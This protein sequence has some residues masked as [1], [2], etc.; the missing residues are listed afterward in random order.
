MV[1]LE[2]EEQHQAGGLSEGTVHH[3]RP[4]FLED[5][6]R[7]PAGSAITVGKRIERSDGSENAISRSQVMNWS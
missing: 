4:I 6:N 2:L 7:W 5:M 3:P 1:N